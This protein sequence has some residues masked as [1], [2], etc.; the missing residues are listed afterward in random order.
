MKIY[1]TAHNYAREKGVIIADTKFEFG[2]DEHTDEIVLIDEVL[3]PDSSR[4]WDEATYKIG[5]SQDS[6]DKQYLRDW[7]T[8]EGLKGKEGEYMTEEVAAETAK[9]YQTVY[10]RLTGKRWE[11]ILD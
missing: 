3:T 4:F 11:T 5:Q 9:R 6:M 1:Q 2:L 10:E 8:G 7:L